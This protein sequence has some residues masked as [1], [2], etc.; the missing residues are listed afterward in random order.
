MYDSYRVINDV[1]H[2][3][4]HCF[5]VSQEACN[6][7]GNC[8]ECRVK[9]LLDYIDNLDREENFYERRFNNVQ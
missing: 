8:S 9:R 4:K 6:K 3:L 1:Q 7:I 2:I 5:N